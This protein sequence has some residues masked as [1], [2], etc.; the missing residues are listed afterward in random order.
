MKKFSIVFLAGCVMFSFGCGKKSPSSTIIVN[1]PDST[2]A[3]SIV[4]DD[5]TDMNAQ[6]NIGAVLGRYKVAH[7]GNASADITWGGGYW[8]AYGSG[9][10]ARILNSDS[11]V[12]LDSA[13]LLQD[14]TLQIAKLMA[15]GTLYADLN[16]QHI[17]PDTAAAWAGIACDLAGDP[18][19]PWVY[20][21]LKFPGDSANYWDLS[22]VD[23]VKITMRGAGAGI[24]FFE[25]KAVKNKFQNPDDAWGFHGFA[26]NF[27]ATMAA[28]ATT[29]AVA[30]K[31]FITWSSEAGTVTWSD[32]SKAVSTF[33]IE[34]DTDND[35]DLEIEVQKIEFVGIDTTAA[36]PFM[37]H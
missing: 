28:T 15:D 3:S 5:F 24:F 30:V 22:S 32:A 19:H 25:S 36:F 31:D 37:K 11:V 17:V 21:S 8:Y 10:G 13:S 27:G 12:V 2:H 34:V 33:A 20:D 4:L 18:E 26:V 1:P 29:Y 35:D 23:T 7:M 9:N 14:D 16:C 6:N